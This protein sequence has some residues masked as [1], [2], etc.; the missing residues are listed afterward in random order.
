MLSRDF[1]YWIPVGG[2]T[3]I[4]TSIANRVMSKVITDF[5]LL[6]QTRH[7]NEVGGFYW[8]F[9]FVLTLLSLPIAITL[10]T[11]EYGESSASITAEKFAKLLIPLTILSFL[12]F[13]TSIDKKYLRT[14]FSFKR[15]KDLTIERFRDST[16]ANKADAIFNNSRHHWE[17]IEGEVETWV[18]ANW[19]LWEEEKPK[20]FDEAI[21]AKIPIEFI[22]TKKSRKLE[23]K[24][25]EINEDQEKTAHTSNKQLTR[26][27]PVGG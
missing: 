2:Y 21:R 27:I 17:S 25:R 22:P 15:G 1:W 18:A 20:W 13:F 19:N 16:D 4:L 26:I 5:T 10:Y 23:T 7:P 14:F 3:E 6:V 8:A 9:G 24:R 11:R 12:V